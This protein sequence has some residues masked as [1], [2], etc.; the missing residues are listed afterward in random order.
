M[1]DVVVSYTHFRSWLPLEA[2]KVQ[3][4]WHGR[5]SIGNVGDLGV[6]KRK[7]FTINKRDMHQRSVIESYAYDILW[8]MALF[9]NGNGSVH[10][11]ITS[12]NINLSLH[13]GLGWWFG[14]LGIHLSNTY[15]LKKI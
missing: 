9:G 5:P 12:Q 8:Q 11:L 13:G 3:R 10:Q 6:S 2:A 7:D 4:T 14:S 1:D 15:C